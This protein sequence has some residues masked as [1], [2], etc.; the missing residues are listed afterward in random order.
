MITKYLESY[1]RALEQ[2]GIFKDSRIKEVFTHVP[3]HLFIRQMYKGSPRQLVALDRHH[4]EEEDLKVIYSDTGIPFHEPHSAASQPWLVAQMLSFLDVQP[5][6]KVLEIGAGSGYNSALLAH[7]VGDEG[8]VYSIDIQEILIDWAKENQ[9]DAGFLK[10]NLRAGD[11]GYGW[12]EAAPFDRIIVTVG[13]ADIP[14]AWLS[15]LSED[16]K[17]LMPF[18]TKELHD[19]LLLL[20]KEGR[21]VRGSFVGFSGFNALQGDYYAVGHS[22]SEGWKSSRHAQRRIITESKPAKVFKMPWLDL[23]ASGWFRWSHLY[24]HLF[25]NM[26]WGWH[27]Q[28][29]GWKWTGYDR[30]LGFAVV[31][32]KDATLTVYGHKGRAWDF[33]HSVECWEALGRPALT[34]YLF[35]VIGDEHQSAKAYR[36]VE[37]RPSIRLGVKIAPVDI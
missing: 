37:A 12:K 29:S 7:L 16:G 28:G 3:R 18:K 23:W 34:Q 4:H 6:M 17:L 32:T 30:V 26:E 5:G 21:Q 31:Q 8:K 15:Q 36:W 11:G 20:R 24:E 10:I 33:C 2:T 19:P 1:V 22:S 13:S 25:R 27:W 14:P 35:E 9:I